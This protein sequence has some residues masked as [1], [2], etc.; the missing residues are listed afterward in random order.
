MVY[1]QG[2]GATKPRSHAVRKDAKTIAK[3]N[4]SE[5]VGTDTTLTL[6]GRLLLLIAGRCFPQ[7]TMLQ[8]QLTQLRLF[9]HP[10]RCFQLDAPSRQVEKNS[11]SV[12][13]VCSCMAYGFHSTHATSPWVEDLV[14]TDTTLTLDGRL[15][16]LIAGR[17]FTQHTTLKKWQLTQLLLCLKPR[18][19]FS[20]RCP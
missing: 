14:E 17:C 8:K 10:G 12:S 18:A 4:C 3:C 2:T 19:M 1:R 7:R 15:L 13:K 11:S 9:L 6:D 5:G 20:A 16:L